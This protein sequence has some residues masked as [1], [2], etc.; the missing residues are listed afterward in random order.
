[1]E[2]FILPG[3]S[4]DLQKATSIATHMVKEWGMSDKIG[5]RTLPEKKSFEGDSMGPATNEL[6]S[7]RGFSFICLSFYNL[8]IIN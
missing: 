1:M 7:I 6:V 3:A 8:L 2:I 4:S 5:P